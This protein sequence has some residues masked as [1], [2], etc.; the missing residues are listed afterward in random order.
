MIITSDYYKELLDSYAGVCA[1]CEEITYE[2][3]PDADGYE[4]EACGANEVVGV[5]L[6]LLID[7]IKIKED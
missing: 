5:E 2:C 1:N 6:A 4:C 7:L 3:E